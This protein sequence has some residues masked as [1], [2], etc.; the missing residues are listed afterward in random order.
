MLKK[1]CF[2]LGSITKKHGFKGEVIFHLDTDRPEAY[3]NLESVLIDINGELVPFFIEKSLLQGNKLRVQLEG[4]THEDQTPHLIGREL[5]L[6]L[7]FLPPLEDSQFYFHEIIGFT[8]QDEK[9][10]VLGQITDVLDQSVQS[11]FVIQN[12]DKE[13]L[14]PAIDPFIV[15]IDKAQKIMYLQTPEGLIDLY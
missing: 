5:F 13:I 2:Q 14:V 8:A 12:S 4:I 15:K 1:D 3:Q 11:L 7:S 9:L 10:G 6:P